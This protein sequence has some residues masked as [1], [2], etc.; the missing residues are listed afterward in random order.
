MTETI[1]ASRL[2][3]PDF[4]TEERPPDHITPARLDQAIDRLAHAYADMSG[5]RSRALARRDPLGAKLAELV[6]DLVNRRITTLSRR[7]AYPGDSR[8]HLARMQNSGFTERMAIGR[9][10]AWR[11]FFPGALDKED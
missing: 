9:I 4:L 11:Y 2:L 8:W 3:L 1:Q 10:R 7:R 6:I 5:C